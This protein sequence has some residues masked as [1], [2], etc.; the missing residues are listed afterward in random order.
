VEGQPPPPALSA[1]VIAHRRAAWA[2]A[3]LMV[4]MKQVRYRF[5][6][7]EALLEETAD[8]A[9]GSPEAGPT[10]LAR[11]AFQCWR[12]LLARLDSLADLV[13]RLYPPPVL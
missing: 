13:A 10:P 3:D 1:D 11:A 9:W 2:G 12:T 7:T 5:Q 4:A 8:L 6:T